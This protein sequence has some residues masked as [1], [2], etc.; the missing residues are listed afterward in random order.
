MHGRLLLLLAALLLALPPP[1]H[2]YTASPPPPRPQ[3]S[4]SLLH[5]SSSSFSSPSSSSSSSH[6][7][8]RDHS[9]QQLLL[10]PAPFV[11]YVTPF[12]PSD[13]ETLEAWYDKVRVASSPC[14]RQC[15]GMYLEYILSCAKGHVDA[16]TH[17]HTC[18]GQGV[19][20]SGG[21]HRAAP[22]QA[23]ALLG[24]SGH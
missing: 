1:H 9:H 3:P 14:Y 6:F 17:T 23:A 11:A 13:A 16:H 8:S 10:P 22:R 20:G 7:Q 19:H 21:R 4:S 24:T 5:M 2:C 12:V 18:T 15:I